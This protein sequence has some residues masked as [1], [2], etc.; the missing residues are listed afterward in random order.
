MS[1]VVNKDR[2][3]D[4]LTGCSTFQFGLFWSFWIQGVWIYKVITCFHPI[5]APLFLQITFKMHSVRWNRSQCYFRWGLFFLIF[6]FSVPN[7]A[8]ALYCHLMPYPPQQQNLTE[9]KIMSWKSIFSAYF[10][11]YNNTNTNSSSIFLNSS[12]FRTILEKAQLLQQTQVRYQTLK[13]IVFIEAFWTI[14]C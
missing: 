7:N 3:L 4:T 13:L 10:N 5:I 1:I 14:V 12:H 8:Y 2:N 6:I 11:E 9:P